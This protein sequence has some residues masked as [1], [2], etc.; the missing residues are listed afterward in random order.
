MKIKAIMLGLVIS[1]GLLL[2]N[3]NQGLTNKTD[4]T[5]YESI[6]NGMDLGLNEKSFK[7]LLVDILGNYAYNSYF[8]S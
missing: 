5:N 2:A 4:P 7:E 1:G 8:I 3:G 6:L